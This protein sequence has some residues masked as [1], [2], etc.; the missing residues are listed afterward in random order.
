MPSTLAVASKVLNEIE[1]CDAHVAF[2]VSGATIASPASFGMLAA[3]LAR[4]RKLAPP[5]L[6]RNHGDRDDP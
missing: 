1:K 5:H 3:L 6:D 2:N 4:R